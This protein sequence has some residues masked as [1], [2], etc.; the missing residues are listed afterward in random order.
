MQTRYA[1]NAPV[2]SDGTRNEP[3]FSH[4]T[5]L[6]TLLA[7]LSA[8]LAGN[9]PLLGKGVNCTA[10]STGVLS[11][12]VLSTV[13]VF[14]YR[15]SSTD[16]SF[17][18]NSNKTKT[19]AVTCT[20]KQYSVGPG[21]III[22]ETGTGK[23]LWASD[24]TGAGSPPPTRTYT[25]L[26]D[27]P[28][29]W[30]AYAEPLTLS[31]GDDSTV[32]R[33]SQPLEQL[34]LTQQLTGYLLYQTDFSVDSGGSGSGSVDG[35][36]GNATLPLLIT[37]RTNN[38]YIVAVDGTV[39]AIL[40]S[41]A[42]MYAFKPANLSANIT[43]L[44]RG[45]QSSG[46]SSHTLSVV[47]IS[48]GL[49]N[50]GIFGDTREAKGIEQVVLGGQNLTRQSWQ[51]RPGLMGERQGAASLSP[52]EAVANASMVWLSTSFN[53]PYDP[54]SSAERP[55]PI[56]VLDASGLGRGHAYV[57]GFDIG[58]FWPLL[59]V[60][61]GGTAPGQ[62]YYHIPAEVLH[63]GDNN[64]LVILEE[65]GAPQPELVRLCAVQLKSDDNDGQTVPALKQDDA[66]WPKHPKWTPTWAMGRSTI[67]MPCNVTGY[68]DPA[69]ASRFG[70]VDVE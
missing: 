14:R 54:H 52:S 9:E 2:H 19:A 68:F 32:V 4:L 36:Q 34:N 47:S 10:A 27:S 37:G 45:A 42:G 17:V 24:K 13:Q 43:F 21:S 67:M 64:S 5:V 53:V 33:S 63:Q 28:L 40:E 50:A 48:L 60:K 46:L 55:P 16:I 49:Q 66:T 39:A 57:N 3:C 15:N 18:E 26:H 65:I 12:G 70:I 7:S 35:G 25:P 20:G 51:Q 59:T 44:R 22:A 58:M 38:G 29:A 23:V 30:Q 11:T 6:H 69:L 1:D 62:R 56:L 41:R 8:V 61:K 31:A